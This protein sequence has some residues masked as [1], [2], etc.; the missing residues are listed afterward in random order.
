MSDDSFKIACPFCAQHIRA[1]PEHVGVEVDCPTCG[2]AYT[3]PPPPEGHAEVPQD[4]YY[5]E[6]PA[7]NGFLTADDFE[8][9][10][11]EQQDVVDRIVDLDPSYW[12]ECSAAAEL[13]EARI[14]PLS[15]CLAT[16][17]Q[18]FYHPGSRDEHIAFLRHIE[19]LCVDFIDIANF[20][21][22][23]LTADIQRS[24]V[25]PGIRSIVDASNK[26]GR[27]VSRI[28]EFHEVLFEH[29]LPQ[30]QPFPELQGIMIG[31]APMFL[32]GLKE[33]VGQLRQKGR[34]ETG[35][36]SSARLNVSLIPADFHKFLFLKQQ[37]S[38]KFGV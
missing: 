27:E 22:R 7:D 1:F 3:I 15:D 30:E 23:A 33:A 21:A 37:L 17:R 28:M 13:I 34:G 10:A 12:W 18:E 36:W 9:M 4:D 31:W 24:V 8:V 14:A 26:V 11:A 2:E 5:A 19:Q 29:S 16:E 38:S 35:D 6:M 25:R 20:L 32:K